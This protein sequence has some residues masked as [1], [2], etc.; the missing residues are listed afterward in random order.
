MFFEVREYAMQP[1]KLEEF[2]Q[3]MDEEIIPFQVGKGMI[4]TGSFVDVENNHY[5]WLRRFENEEE[6]DRLYKAVY[7]SDY[8]KTEASPRIGTLID[9]SQIRV[10]IVQA[11]P[12]SILR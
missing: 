7:E 3:Y 9:R 6:R 8:W 10:S 2:V 4:I 5:F 1:G 11:T 12:R